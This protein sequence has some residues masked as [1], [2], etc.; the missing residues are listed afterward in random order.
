MPM[1][2]RFGHRNTP[3]AIAG[4]DQAGSL[5]VFDFQF[6]PFI[7]NND[8]NFP[9]QGIK[10]LEGAL[11]DFLAFEIKIDAFLQV[12][13]PGFQLFHDLFEPLQ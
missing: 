11:A 3:G 2:G 1:M 13:F 7:T 10:A 8:L 9:F 12:G 6:I 4:P 5:E